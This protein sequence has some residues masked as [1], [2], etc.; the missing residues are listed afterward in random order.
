MHHRKALVGILPDEVRVANHGVDFSPVVAP[1]FQS[2]A[3]CRWLRDAPATAA[4]NGFIG[5]DPPARLPP[6]L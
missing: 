4:V 2:E 1:P 6:T 3:V 5:A